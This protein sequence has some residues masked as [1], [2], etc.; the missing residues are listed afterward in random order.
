MASSTWTGAGADANWSTKENWVGNV[1]PATTGVD[2]IFDSNSTARLSNTNDRCTNVNS[3]TQSV[4][5]AVTVSISAGIGTM[6]INAGITQTS[7]G[8]SITVGS[9]SRVVQLNGNQT[10]ASNKSSGSFPVN[11]N[12]VDLNGYNLTL[13]ATNNAKA[14]VS[15]MSGTGDV[16]VGHTGNASTEIKGTITGTGTIT[17][18]NGS[19]N[20]FG[21]GTT[22][23]SCTKN[24]IINSGATL[25]VG[26]ITTTDTTNTFSGTMTNNGTLSLVS[27]PTTFSKDSGTVLN[28]AG[29]L[30]FYFN[31]EI[32]GTMTPYLVAL[33]AGTANLTLS[34]KVNIVKNIVNTTNLPYYSKSFLTYTG[35]LTNNGFL[36]TNAS[37]GTTITGATGAETKYSYS[38]D[39]STAG[40]IK[41]NFLRRNECQPVISPGCDF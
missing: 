25:T 2:I 29:T 8:S 23:N 36:I 31:V 18:T 9:T 13:S 10:F 6:Q 3:I 26:R 14:M 17:Y 21:S 27:F 1:A 38:V 15:N 12:N 39:T 4:T 32:D 28:S 7:N 30:N 35:A 22:I 37:D 24:I 34:G 5:N 40:V 11:V 33:N 41:G 20:L 19:G 16:S